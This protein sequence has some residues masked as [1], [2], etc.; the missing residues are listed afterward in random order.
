MYRAIALALLLASCGEDTTQSPAD[1]G[2]APLDGAPADTAP[3]LRWLSVSAGGAHTCAVRS[4]HTAWCWGS[5]SNGQ[6]G[7]G[8]SPGP[9]PVRV[10][11]LSGV[12]E[13]SAD[14]V[15]SC[16]ATADG[17]A[18][19]WG[20]N[21]GMQLG[22]PK[23][24][25]SYPSCVSGGC[26]E[27]VRV[28]Q[29]TGVSAVGTG[30]R[31]S[32]AVLADGQVRCWGFNELGQLG[33]GDM[34]NDSASPSSVLG[35]VNAVSVVGSPWHTC[36]AT[37]DGKAYCWGD[38]ADGN[39]GVD[40]PLESDQ[41]I[42]V[43]GVP[44]VA[45]VA[46]GDVHTCART[47]GGHVLCFG[48]NAAGQL[49]SGTTEASATALEVSG[50]TGVRSIAAGADHSCAVDGQGVVWCWG[51]NG[52][53]ANGDGQPEQVTGKLGQGATI[54]NRLKP[55][56]VAG[57]NNVVAVTAG[58]D[59]TCALTAPGEI[60][61]WGSNTDGQLGGGTDSGSPAPRRVDV[62]TEE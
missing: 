7:G 55:V 3:G 11:G 62:P 30:A 23:A 49:G 61:C 6:L 8:P 50:P 18:Y 43:P 29:L 41:P 1:Q 56:T 22:D 59:H 47:A 5:N 51:S 46:V 44:N 34:P 25:A 58:D 52:T 20:E 17:A 53:D 57:V 37:K 39:L 4:D 9:G 35:L 32:C 38:N 26:P 31:H 45:E 14:W 24:E 48:G 42:A 33:D 40:D 16:A 2:A 36:A 54:E 60:W 28:V 19:C 13:V 12:E 15:H 10:K 27:P 21:D